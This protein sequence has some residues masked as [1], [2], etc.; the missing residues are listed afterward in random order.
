MIIMSYFG[1]SIN[2]LKII[3]WAARLASMGEDVPTLADT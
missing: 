2:F 3:L 1:F